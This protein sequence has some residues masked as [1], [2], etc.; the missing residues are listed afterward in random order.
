MS[1]R[2][3]MIITM[4]MRNKMTWRMIQADRLRKWLIFGIY[5]FSNSARISLKPLP[6]VVGLKY[7]YF[8]FKIFPYN[9]VNGT[10]CH[11]WFEARQVKTFCWS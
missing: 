8:I 5:S 2:M 4:T 1:V 6:N 3:K 7:F 11:L 9:Q 10:K